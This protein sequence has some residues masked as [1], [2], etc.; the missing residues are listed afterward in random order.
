M[1]E[2]HV[3]HG[4]EHVGEGQKTCYKEGLELVMKCSI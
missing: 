4:F 3:N 2:M 1:G